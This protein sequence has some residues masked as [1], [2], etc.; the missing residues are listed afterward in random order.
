MKIEIIGDRKMIDFV[1][2]YDLFLEIDKEKAFVYDGDG[3]YML[4]IELK[5]KSIEFVYCGRLKLDFIKDLT[6][7]VEKL[8]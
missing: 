4:S 5:D 3:E 1:K 6:K 7:M 2:K 8:V